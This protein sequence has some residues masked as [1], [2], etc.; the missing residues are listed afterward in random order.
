MKPRLWK[1]GGTGVCEVT[2]DGATFRAS[3]GSHA[4][5]FRRV[6]PGWSDDDADR[7]ADDIHR[8]PHLWCEHFCDSADGCMNC[9]PTVEAGV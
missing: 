1:F 6:D 7:M 2:Y 4:G 9:T 5:E 3:S 8:D